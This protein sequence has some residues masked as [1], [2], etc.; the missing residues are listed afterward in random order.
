MAVAVPWVSDDKRDAFSSTAGYTVNP[1]YDP[2][3]AIDPESGNWIA[4]SDKTFVVDGM[5]A[6]PS[7]GY[8]VDAL[9]LEDPPGWSKGI[10][11]TL[12][13]RNLCSALT[14]VM[15]VGGV[16]WCHR[17][18]CSG[19]ARQFRVVSD[20]N[21]ILYRG[22]RLHRAPSRSSLCV[23]RAGVPEQHQ[24]SGSNSHACAQREVFYADNSMEQSVVPLRDEG[25]S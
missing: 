7:V 21:C 10:Q 8:V 1:E 12:R 18:R 23:C 4:T 19:T 24:N 16:V 14:L 20:R 22:F 3:E 9:P 25:A 11:R 2:G 17:L 15:F 5:D 13:I 6:E